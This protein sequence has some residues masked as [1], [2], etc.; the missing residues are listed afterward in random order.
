M[1]GGPGAGQP[2]EGVDHRGVALH[3]DGEGEVDGAGEPHLGEGEQ[4]RHQPRV[5]AL[6][7]HADT[8]KFKYLLCM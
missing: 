5:P 1:A 3:A 2:E 8:Y 4:H 7:P 6:R